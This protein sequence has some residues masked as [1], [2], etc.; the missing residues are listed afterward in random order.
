MNDPAAL[1]HR[2]VDAVLSFAADVQRWL[3]VEAA[4]A[5]ACATAGLVEPGHA[6]AIADACRVD[7]ID[8][9]ALDAAAATAATPIIPLVRQLEAAVPE[10]ARAAVHLGATSQD[11]I[12]TATM[13]ALREGLRVVVE[14]LVGAGHR[15]AELAQ[16]ERDTVMAGRTL[17]QQAVPITFGL[18][19]ARWLTALVRQLERLYELG[20]PV[21]LGSAA[22]TL[23][24][25][26]P[27]GLEVLTRFAGELDLDVPAL[28]W[29]AERDDLHAIV[30][31][32]ALVAATC[33]KIAGD[34]VLLAQTEVGE[35][36]DGGAGGSS[37]MPHKRNPVDATFAVAAARLATTEAGAILVAGAHEHERGAGAWQAEW[38]AV[39]RVLRATAVAAARVRGAL[40]RL[41]VDADRMRQNLAWS[42]GNLGSEPL[43]LALAAALGRQAAHELVEEL[44]E[45]A[46][47]EGRDLVEVALGEP[48]VAELLPADQRAR[49][50]DPA[51][52][53]GSASPLI[54]RALD[55]WHGVEA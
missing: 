26:G 41:E 37:T 53:L 46:G 52:Y 5:R 51:A 2:E 1:R 55:R 25:Y 18:K 31:A 23:A 11:V 54:D 30:A 20:F 21:Q 22:G 27:R 8:L 45:R 19:A 34:L 33:G 10:H 28:P 9:E 16:Q 7:R 14:E 24:P 6:E 42:G 3:D 17:L 43:A 35:V 38:A 32:M 15:C 48:R 47:A 39:P 36:V 40:E 4:L 29:H 50:A 12:D 49:L 13:L 44:S